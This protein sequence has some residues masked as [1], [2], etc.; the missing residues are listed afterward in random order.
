MCSKILVHGGRRG[1]PVLVIE[2]KVPDTI[3]AREVKGC[4]SGNLREMSASD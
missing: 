3:S 1:D 4:K 2:D